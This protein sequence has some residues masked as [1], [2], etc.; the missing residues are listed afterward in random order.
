MHSKKERARERV[1]DRQ[2]DICRET[3]IYRERRREI[4]YIERAIHTAIKRDRQRAIERDIK[5]IYI[6]RDTNTHSHRE[7]VREIYIIYREE[8]DTHNHIERERERETER[9]ERRDSYS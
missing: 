8:R 5:Y 7:I 9:N 1:K 2:I 3:D 4:Y 6:E